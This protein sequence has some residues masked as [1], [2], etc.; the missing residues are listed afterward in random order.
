MS[1]LSSERKNILEQSSGDKLLLRERQSDN[2]YFQCQ[3]KF[4][5]N[6]SES[7][8]GRTID[9][10]ELRQEEGTDKIVFTEYPQSKQ[11]WTKWSSKSQNRN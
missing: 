9:V 11:S 10:Y 3:L 1:N 7:Q 4:H 6:E 5:E 8:K 2:N